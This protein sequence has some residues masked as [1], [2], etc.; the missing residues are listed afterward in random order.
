MNSLG[1]LHEKYLVYSIVSVPC[2]VVGSLLYRIWVPPKSTALIV[3]Q[4]HRMKIKEV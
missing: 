4:N 2:L 1:F 3:N